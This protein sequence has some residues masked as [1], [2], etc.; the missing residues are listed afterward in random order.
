MEEE[1]ISKLAKP[2]ESYNV[3]V[4]IHC[5]RLAKPVCSAVNVN[6]SELL[7]GICPNRLETSEND[8]SIV[9]FLLSANNNRFGWRSVRA[10]I[11]FQK[12]SARDHH[13]A[14]ITDINTSEDLCL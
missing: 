10:S 9:Y 12:K 2:V 8:R 14:V 13:S 3:R 6:K 1:I 5:H 4:H 11:H 7:L